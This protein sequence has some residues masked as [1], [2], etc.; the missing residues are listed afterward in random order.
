MFEP[1][2]VE[3]LPNYCLRLRY[4]DGYAGEVDLSRFAGQGVFALWD[5]PGSFERVRIS[6]EGAI[7]WSDEVEICGDS[8]YLEITGRRPDEVFPGL[9]PLA[10]NA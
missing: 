3:A 6:P 9:K 2:E 5:E 8:L 4:A 10:A 1:I 7:A